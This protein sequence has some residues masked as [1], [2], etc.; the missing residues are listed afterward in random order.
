MTSQ[1][2]KSSSTSEA[3]SFLLGVA[4]LGFSLWLLSFLQ[5][6]VEWKRPKG[7]LFHASNAYA[8]KAPLKHAQKKPRTH[9]MS[10]QKGSYR[11][12]TTHSGKNSKSHQ[13]TQYCIKGFFGPCENL[14]YPKMQRCDKKA[15]KGLPNRR[16]PT[17]GMPCRKTYRKGCTF[18]GSWRCSSKTGHLY[19]HTRISEYKGKVH[20]QPLRIRPSN[21]EFTLFH[22]GKKTKVKGKHCLVFTRRRARV[23]LKG[24]GYFRC[25]FRIRQTRRIRRIKML[26]TRSSFIR[27]GIPPSHCLR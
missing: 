6:S 2:S 11:T 18:S 22:S 8:Q 10:C 7:S 27:C 12:C 13:G 4:G 24:E 9:R 1:R 21:K 16:F 3:F 15:R 26:R 20:L 5:P 17:K 23:T 25:R 14:H 19:C